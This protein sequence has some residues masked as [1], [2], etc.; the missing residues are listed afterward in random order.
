ME[1]PGLYL[2]ERFTPKYITNHVVSTL[3]NSLSSAD[4]KKILPIYFVEY[5]NNFCPYL[6]SKK[7]CLLVNGKFLNY[8]R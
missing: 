7:I 1:F 8:I 6:L 3:Y 4:H 2:K 5:L